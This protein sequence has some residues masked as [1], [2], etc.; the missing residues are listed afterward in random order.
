[1]LKPVNYETYEV[2]TEGTFLKL[3][4]GK[5]RIRI[6]TPMFEVIQHEMQDGGKWS[7][8]KCDGDGCE[9][10]AKGRKKRLRFACMVFN[11]SENNSLKVWEMGASI[12][13]QVKAFSEDPEYGDPVQYDVTVTKEGEKLATT[14]TI[15][16]S[17]KKEA[18]T[19][20]ELAQLEGYA[21]MIEEAYKKD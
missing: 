4:P 6:A 21:D 16:P 19:K 20:D 10:C 9:H 1:M 11:R 15:V 8:V 13:S 3:Q 5:T 2:Q 12:F 17:P 14:Y 7:T 18:L